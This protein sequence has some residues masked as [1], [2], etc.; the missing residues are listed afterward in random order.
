MSTGAMI[1]L[2]VLDGARIVTGSYIGNDEPSLEL[3]FGM[4]A[5]MVVITPNANRYITSRYPQ[6]LTMRGA[7]ELQYFEGYRD[8]YIEW[9]ETGVIFE[10]GDE[11]TMSVNNSAY[12]YLYTVL[13]KE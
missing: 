6:F 8:A 10:S 13:G 5:L 4:K 2:P 3:D 11:G 1:P 9:T 7:E 12:T